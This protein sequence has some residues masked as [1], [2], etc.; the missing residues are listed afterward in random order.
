MERPETLEGLAEAI[1]P[2]DN[3]LAEHMQTLK[4]VGCETAEDVLMYWTEGYL[5][6]VREQLLGVGLPTASALKSWRKLT[7]Y[8]MAWAKLSAA[9]AGRGPSLLAQ[10][11]SSAP[12]LPVT[13]AQGA[14]ACS[15][16]ASTNSSK[17]PGRFAKFRQSQKD[18]LK[19][20]MEN[21]EKF[22]LK[23]DFKEL[24]MRHWQHIDDPNSDALGAT[25]VLKAYCN[26]EFKT[27][28]NQREPTLEY[29]KEGAKFAQFPARYQDTIVSDVKAWRH[30]GVA[31]VP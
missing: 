26:Q 22:E 20:M 3:D 27:F 9:P 2:E 7:T 14:S 1:D 29:F 28:C 8:M 10:D 21:I 12:S 11:S 19:V 25:N 5:E 4:E 6:K 23:A 24:L 18:E 15:S 30:P 17:P 13:L 16:S 31:V